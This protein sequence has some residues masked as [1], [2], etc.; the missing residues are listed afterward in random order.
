MSTH[1]AAVILGLD[2]R[3]FLL[4]GHAERSATKTGS[5]VKPE[6]VSAEHREEPRR[7]LRVAVSLAVFALATLPALAQT[8]PIPRTGDGRPDFHGYWFTGFITPMERPDGITS[9]AVAP[10]NAASLVAR[11]MEDLDEGEVYDPEFDSNSIAPALL[12]MNGELRSSRIVVPPDGQLPLTALAK[13]ALDGEESGFDNP[14]NRPPPERCIEGLVNAPLASSFLM[15][16]LQLVQTR[17]A[18]VMMMED[19]EPARIVTL[20]T[21]PR[22]DALR[23]RSG[24]SRGRWEGDTLVVETDRFNIAAK[25]GITW[26]GGAFITSDSKVIERFTLTSTDTLLY[27]FTV[28]DLS[29]YTKPWRAE[30]MFKRIRRP[31]YEYACHEANHALVHILLAARLGKQEIK[32]SAQ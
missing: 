13:A 6:K 25:Q 5:R 3:V 24:Q 30:Y 1:V 28:E 16:P 29:V 10:E 4:F 8:S 2:P 31:A 20:T 9:L 18:V 15:V 26:S 17:D 11:L 12:D 14:E 27:R 7:G 23:T 21:P 32:L 19:M 22:P